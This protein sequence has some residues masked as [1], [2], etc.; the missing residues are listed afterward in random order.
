METISLCMIVRNEI[1]VLER[2]LKSAA[3][4]YDEL[5]IVDTGSEDGTPELAR[6]F[7][8]RVFSFPWRDNFSAARNFAFDQAVSAY[9]MWLDAD[10]VLLPADRDAFLAVKAQELPAADVVMARYQSLRP[11]GS[12]ALSYYR[13]RILRNV[14]WLRWAGVVHE[15]IPPAGNVV[16]TEAAVTHQKERPGDP[17]RNL[18]ILEGLR[19]AGRNLSPR[20]QFYY[21]RELLDHGR[22]REAARELES[23][24]TLGWGWR[25]N[26]I[27]ACRLLSA[28]YRSLG[29]SRLALRALLESLA[30]DAPRAEVCCDLGNL[31]NNIEACRLLSACYRSL[32]QSRL[33]LRALLESLAFDAPRAEVC[34]DLGNLFL[35]RKDYAAAARWYERAL[36]CHRD[37]RSGAFIQPDCYGYLPAIGLCQCWY[38]LGDPVRAEAWNERAEAFRPGDPACRHNRA[39]FQNAVH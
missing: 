13:E 39:F 33:A 18:R 35:A 27:E 12:P 11:D 17:D 32:G 6:Q 36:S 22:F 8:Q 2:C 10:D 20:E 19:G 37:D 34:C 7:T 9:C 4:L 14:P 31:F 5:V 21:G 28:C 38:H 23:F 16:Y 25:E 24:L 30:F 26:N 15:A 29:Q 3:G 1:E